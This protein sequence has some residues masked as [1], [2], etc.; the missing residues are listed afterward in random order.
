MWAVT[1]CTTTICI[2][3]LLVFDT[4]G[5]IAL[6]ESVYLAGLPRML[7]VSAVLVATSMGALIW[8]FQVRQRNTTVPTPTVFIFVEEE[9][10]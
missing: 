9:E 5:S 10:P 8:Y 4:I 7:G 3:T 2:A 1:S 6:I